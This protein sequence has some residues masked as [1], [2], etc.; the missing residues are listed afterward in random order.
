MKSPSSIIPHS[1]ALIAHTITSLSLPICH[2]NPWSPLQLRHCLSPSVTTIPDRPYN[3]VT[4]SPHLSLQSLIAHTITSLSLP[5]CHYNPWSPLQLRHCLSPSVTTIPDRPYSYVTVSPHLSLQSL[6]AL[7][8]TSLSLP[9][10][11]YN[12]WSPLQLRHCLSPSVTTIPDRPYNYVTVSPHLSLQSLIALTATSLSL[13]I[14]HYNPWSPL[15]LRHCLSPSVTTIPDRPYNYVTVSPH[16]SL[17]SLIALTITSLSLPICHYNPW[18]P[19]QLRHCLS[20]SVTTIPD[21]PYSYVT[22]SPSLSLQSLI[23]LTVPSLSL[24]ICHYNPWSPL[25]FRHCLFPSVTTITDRPYSYVTVFPSLSLQ[26]LIVTSLSPPSVTTIPD[27]PYSS[28]TVSPHLSLQSLI[29]LTVPS[30][31]LPICHYNHWS[32]LQVRHCLSPSVTTIPDRPYSSVTVS[33]HLSLQSLVAY[34]V[35]S[36]SFPICH[37]NPWSPIQLR[38]CLS[39]SVTTIPDCPYSYVTFFPHLSIPYRPY[40]HITVCSHLSLQSLIAHTVTSLFFPICHYNPWLNIQLRHCLP[41]T[42]TTIPDRPYNYVTVFPHLSLQSLIAHTVT[43]LSFPICQSPIAHTV[44]SPS[45]PICHYNP[46]LNIQLRHCLP[47][48]VTTIHDCPYSYVIVSPHL[49]LQSLIALTIA[50]LSFPICHYNPWLPK[51]LRHCLS[52]SVITIPD[53]PYNYVTVFPHL[54]LLCHRALTTMWAFVAIR[55]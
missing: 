41:P 38:H 5:I 16:L 55:A 15:Q 24:P 20:P 46:W 49:S 6:I 7:T 52:P 39:P 11:H 45:V 9:I 44:T 26:S 3:Y 4:V 32:P 12:P 8:I 34:T 47:P 31:S 36:L 27:R 17:Q 51:Q 14:C 50:S 37:Y 23:A 22:V 13:P 35:T 2:Y 54:L 28:V 48:S 53:C 18:S 25:Q 1:N 29:A 30:L 19:L 43:S 33:P 40:S 42:V 21:R 10:C